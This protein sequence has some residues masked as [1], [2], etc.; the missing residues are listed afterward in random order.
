VLDEE[1]RRRRAARLLG[2][3]VCDEADKHQF[4]LHAGVA[5]PA[6]D[7]TRLEQLCRYVLRPPIAQDS[8]AITPDGRLRLELR[9]PWRDGTRALLFDPLDF[10]ARLAALTR[11]RASIYYSTTA[12]SA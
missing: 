11:S 4:D 6:G 5:V 1:R 12:S 10:L 3:Q 7:R 9:R 2:W 8:L